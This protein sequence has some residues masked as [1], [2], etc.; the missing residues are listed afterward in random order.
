MKRRDSVQNMPPFPRGSMEMLQ[1]VAPLLQPSVT[2]NAFTSSPPHLEEG[3]QTEGKL[4]YSPAL[5]CLQDFN[6]ARAQLE[7]KQS[8]EAQKLDCKNAAHDSRWREDMS[9]NG[10][11]WPGKETI[12]SQKCFQ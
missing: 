6:Q 11:E 3:I 7:S 9:R 5:Q 2:I 10:Q 1:R 12:P 4:G 8:E